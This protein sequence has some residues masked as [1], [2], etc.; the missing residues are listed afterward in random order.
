MKVARIVRKTIAVLL[1]LVMALVVISCG[2]AQTPSP[3]VPTI[4][5]YENPQPSDLP[6][7]QEFSD[8]SEFQISPKYPAAPEPPGLPEKRIPGTLPDS[9]M[10][11]YDPEADY[12]ARPRFKI[13]Y[14]VQNNASGMYTTFGNAFSHWAALM[15]IEYQGLLDFGGDNEMLLAELPKL[16]RENDGLIIDPDATSF[17]RVKEI[18]DS[19]GTPWMPFISAPRDYSA[20]GAPLIHPWVGFDYYD[21][22][23][24]FP[25]KLLE[26]KD[27]LWPDVPLAEFGFMT[28]DNLV[29]PPLHAL[30]EGAYAAL[31]NLNPYFA[32]NR[33]FV[34]DA[35]YGPGDFSNEWHSTMK[36]LERNPDIKYWLVFAGLNDIAEG[37]ASAFDEMSLSDNACIASVDVFQHHWAYET[38]NPM[39]L[40]DN[41]VDNAWGLALHI[42]NT[43]WAEP[44][45][46]ALYAYM[47]GQAE[48]ETIWPEWVNVDDCGSEGKSYAT[49]LAPSYW[50]DRDNYREVLKWTDIYAGT[51]FYPDYP[52]IP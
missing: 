41:G 22:G 10:G 34:A 28:I 18:M 4:S 11:M 27:K 15:N 48:P 42:P 32:A 19:A 25:A 21:I 35:S 5:E 26:Y 33:Y 30:A 31:V 17:S 24:Q 40:W 47:S 23:A 29:V 52:E 37:V 20:D 6:A 44:V 43:I 9:K 39:N 50:V 14:V 7:L 36:I 51:D 16:A 8:M 1:A 46:G 49:R 3:G 12:N 2:G 45:V 13:T 38:R